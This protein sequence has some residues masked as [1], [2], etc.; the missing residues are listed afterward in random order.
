[1]KCPNCEMN[2]KDGSTFCIHCGSMW[3][4]IESPA[5]APSLG[6]QATVPG[7][8]QDKPLYSQNSPANKLMNQSS[9]Q[10]QL[11]NRQ[12]RLQRELQIDEYVKEYIGP[13]Y[14]KYRKGFFSWGALFFTYFYYIAKGLT[15]EGIHWF[16]LQVGIITVVGI[17][18]ILPII[19]YIIA[20]IGI[21]I[22]LKVWYGYSSNYTETYLR[23]Q[24]TT[25]EEKLKEKEQ[26]TPDDIAA[27]KAKKEEYE[28][29]CMIFAIIFGIIS[30]AILGLCISKLF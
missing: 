22:L 28:K 2:I 18:G 30:C 20:I 1:M 19:G 4:N 10:T 8:L 27:L 9:A 15:G 13:Q 26:L 25:I 12:I 7:L 11:M 3:Q 5:G 21:I 14:E 23:I 17:G 6:T 29:K 16:L 24:R